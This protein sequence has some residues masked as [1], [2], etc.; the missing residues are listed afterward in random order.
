M[1]N[2]EVVDLG[3]WTE[4][5]IHRLL[6]YTSLLNTPGQRISFLSSQFLLTPYGEST[7]IGNKDREVFTINLDRV[8][9]LTF[10]EYIEAMRISGSFNEFKENLKRVRYRGGNVS[11]RKRNHFFTDWRIHNKTLVRDVTQRISDKCA[12]VWKHL[13]RKDKG[14]RWIPDIPVVRRKIRYIASRLIDAHVVDNLQTGDYTGIY[15]DDE[16]LDV[17]HVGIIIK[18]DDEIFLRHASSHK[19]HRRVI[20]EDFR[21]YINRKPGIIVFRPIAP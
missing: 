6:G 9:C 14:A 5:E 20:D 15:S 3:P 10:I 8:D 13:N 19:R 17:S 21:G 7:L 16:G 1:V 4:G 11:F 2:R 18:Y 12:E